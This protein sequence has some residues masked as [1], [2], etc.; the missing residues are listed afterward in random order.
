MQDP[1]LTQVAEHCDR[2]AG[3]RHDIKMRHPLL[4]HRLFEF[5]ASLPTTQTFRA[6]QRKIIMR[7]AMR[8][9]L[10]D[11]IVNMW[12]KITPETI[13]ERGLREREQGKVWPLLAHMRAA[14]LG[15]V[16]EARL[17]EAYQ[18]YVDRK[19]NDSLFWYTLTL[20]DWLRRYF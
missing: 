3:A 19:T 6:G 20:E 17:R 7:N 15:L 9:L 1:F 4:D 10:P 12:G 18:S 2:R 13:S 11:D 8:G 5:A 16:D 14:E